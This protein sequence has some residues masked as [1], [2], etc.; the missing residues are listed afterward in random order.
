[1]GRYPQF[2][3]AVLGEIAAVFTSICWTFSSII[4]TFAGRRVGA[5]VLNRMRLTFAVLWVALI[6]L[7]LQGR[8]FPTDASPE[9]WI[10]LGLSGVAGLVVGD[11][12]LFQGYVMIGPRISTL[13]MSLSPVFSAV[14]ALLFLNETLRAGQIIGILVTIAGV[15]LVVLDHHGSQE[16]PINR[17]RYLLGAAGQTVGLILAKRGLEGNFPSISGLAIRMLVSVVFVWLL[18]LVSGQARPT[19][20]SMRDRRAFGLILGGSVVGP[21]L[22][23]WLSIIS[24]QQAP[25]GVASTLMSLTPIFLIPAGFWFF[26]ERISRWAIVG[27]VISIAGVVI[28]FL[29]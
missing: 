18:A 27:T 26:R 22:G 6:H 20:N 23:I 11:L 16:T 24:I 13:I 2:K 4:F 25:I 9:R 28:L 8:L 5:A 15:A 17:K 14:L 29:L 12:L 10:W 21:F 7:L 3:V 1:M 19:L